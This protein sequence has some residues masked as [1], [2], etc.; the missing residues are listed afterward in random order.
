MNELASLGVIL[1][2]A[3]LAG[4]LV[5]F[6]QGREVPGYLLAGVRVGH[7]LLGGIHPANLET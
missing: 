4:H 5:K 1:F 3:L 7:S 2:F 6:L